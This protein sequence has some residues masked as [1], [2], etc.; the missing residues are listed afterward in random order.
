[1]NGKYIY[2]LDFPLLHLL[3]LSLFHLFITLPYSFLIYKDSNAR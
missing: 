1:M 2:S 3:S